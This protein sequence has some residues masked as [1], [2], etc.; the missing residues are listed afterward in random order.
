MNTSKQILVTLCPNS[1]RSWKDDVFV[2][3]SHS[4]ECDLCNNLRNFFPLLFQIWHKHSLGLNYL[5]DTDQRSMSRDF[6]KTVLA[7]WMQ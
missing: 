1:R 2:Y 5:V 4:P 3:Q 6:T 7:L